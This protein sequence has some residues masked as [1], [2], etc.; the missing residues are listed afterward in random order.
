MK[1]IFESEFSG[2][3][4]STQKIYVYEFGNK[5]EFW[6]FDEMSFKEKC[7]YFGVCEEYSVM[8]GALFHRYGFDHSSTYVVVYETIA[9]NV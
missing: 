4:E 2:D 8:P 7:E 1:K 9:Y 6:K 5:D 3:F